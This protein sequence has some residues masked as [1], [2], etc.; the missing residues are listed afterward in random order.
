M[1]TLII[2][3]V[4]LIIVQTRK[5]AGLSI[6]KHS[7]ENIGTKQQLASNKNEMKPIVIQK[8]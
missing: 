5:I 8:A 4:V 7:D 2:I 6:E 3:L 1:I